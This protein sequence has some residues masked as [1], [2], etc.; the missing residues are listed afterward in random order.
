MSLKRVHGIVNYCRTKVR[1]G[2]VEAVNANIRLLTNQG[3]GYKNLRYLLLK[4][5]E[6]QA[7]VE[8]LAVE[9]VKQVA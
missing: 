9:R 2:V 8:F 6:W 7:N 1:F 4:A 3:S 5:S